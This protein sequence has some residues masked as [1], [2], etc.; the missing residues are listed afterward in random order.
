MAVGAGAVMDGEVLG[1][2]H[3]TEH[4]LFLG[5]EKYKNPSHFVDFIT[6][7][8][9]SRN[10][11]TKM[12]TTIFQFKVDKESFN[13]AFDIFSRFFIDPLILPDFVEKE[14]NSVNSEYQRNCQLDAN[15]KDHVFRTLANKDSFFPRFRTGNNNT[16]I[17]YA[18]SK[19]L[20]LTKLVRDYF[21]DYYV[22]NNMKLVIYGTKDFEYYKNLV[23]RT[24]QGLKRKEFKP[25]VEKHRPFNINNLGYFTMHKSLKDHKEMDIIFPIP[26]KLYMNEIEENCSNPNTYNLNN[27][28]LY[29]KY[30]M[31][32]KINGTLMESLLQNG[33]ATA[34]RSRIK[35]YYSGFES[36]VITIQ[37]TEKGLTNINEVINLIFD[38]LEFLSKN[39]IPDKKLFDLVKQYFDNIFYKQKFKIGS[40]RFVKEFSNAIWDYPDK[41]LLSTKKLL[42][43]YDENLLKEFA[44]IFNIKNSIIMLGSKNF[45]NL[46]PF[47]R[48]NLFIND[49]QPKTFLTYHEHWLNTFFGVY[50]LND[51][52]I[53]N[54]RI[55]I[56]KEKEEIAHT[57][58][59]A[60]KTFHLDKLESSFKNSSSTKKHFQ[61]IC[62]DREC[63]KVILRDK[64]ELTPDILVKNNYSEVLH[65]VCISLK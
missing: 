42:N 31:N 44:S 63:K 62:E 2:A 18:K 46:G 9:G 12:N 53:V 60:T 48:Y 10:G 52:A 45:E 17:D 50:K 41:F 22:P 16:L 4:M 56:P 58:F 55:Q 29:F 26:E 49:F 21:N 30:L 7:K 19:N 32:Q 40:Y 24:F 11:R 27:P 25:I 28:G 35:T 38:Y 34:M 51:K 65:K 13:D 23:E 54:N 33:F 3:F 20:S 64:N 14:M 57:N 8:R 39:A 37:L 36:F 6:S 1:L 5:S 47:K 43:E 59:I 61:P 15:K